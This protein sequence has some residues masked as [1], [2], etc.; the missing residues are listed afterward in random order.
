MQNITTLPPAAIDINGM[1][2]VLA[3]GQS[4][5]PAALPAAFPTLRQIH[6]DEPEDTG[7]S[8]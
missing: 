6:D 1:N 3:T 4:G 5:A 2:F 8:S 7:W